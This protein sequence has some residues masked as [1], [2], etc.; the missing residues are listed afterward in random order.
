MNAAGVCH[1]INSPISGI[2]SVSMLKVSRAEATRHLSISGLDD[3]RRFRNRATS[4]ESAQKS[5]FI[6]ED[7]PT[8]VPKCTWHSARREVFWVF[9]ALVVLHF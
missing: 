6:C 3:I 8:E 9:F 7:F 1:R 4:R 2:H 5:N